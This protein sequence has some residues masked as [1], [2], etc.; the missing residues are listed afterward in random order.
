MMANKDPN[1]KMY[2]LL[3]IS[4]FLFQIDLFMFAVKTNYETFL[5]IRCLLIISYSKNG[6]KKMHQT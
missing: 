1:I 4:L 3:N 6:N 2:P 5:C